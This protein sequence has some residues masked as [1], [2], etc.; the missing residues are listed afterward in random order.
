MAKSVEVCVGLFG[1][2]GLFGGDIK[3]VAQSM[4]LAEDCGID[5]VSITD[6]VVMGSRADQYPYG[7]FPLPPQA[8]WYEPHSMLC[9]IAALTQSIKLSA[10]V[11]ISPLRPTVLFAKQMATLDVLSG[12]RVQIGVGTGWQREEFDAEGLDYD[13]RFQ[14]LEDQIRACRQLWTEES[15]T[16]DLETV[17]LK[18]IYCHPQPVQARLPVW[19]GLK[20]LARNARRMA[21]LGDGWIPIVQDPQEIARGVEVLHRAYEA[22]GRSADELAVRAMPVVQFT[23][24]GAPDL[25]ATLATAQT[26]IDAGATCL[27]FLPLY[28]A[29]ESEQLDAVYKSIASIRV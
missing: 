16:L 25:D 4:A 3:A 13:N 5:Q 22:A 11:I 6:H 2:E 26:Y 18:E 24:A 17:Q 14:L 1:M 20:P 29:Q 15:V 23:Q 10:G 12:G 21:E 28:F 19:F 7:D 27:E 9:A 8:P